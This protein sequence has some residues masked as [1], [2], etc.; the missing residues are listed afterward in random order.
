MIV[1]N[2]Q[3]FDDQKGKQCKHDKTNDSWNQ[4]EYGTWIQL[5]LTPLQ[6]VL[7]AEGWEQPFELHIRISKS[8]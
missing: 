4:Q 1:A 5:P 8:V 2:Q 6:C 3:E 7:P